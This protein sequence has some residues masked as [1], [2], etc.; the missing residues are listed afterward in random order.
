MSR[1]RRS[2]MDFESKPAASKSA[3]FNY[4]SLTK[5]SLSG[6]RTFGA[7]GASSSRPSKT[8]LK[9]KVT[10][11]E[12]NGLKTKD[13]NQMKEVEKKRPQVTTKLI[14]ETQVPEMNSSS[15]SLGKLHKT[16]PKSES[17]KTKEKDG[18][19]PKTVSSK[20]KEKVSRLFKT[21]RNSVSTPKEMVKGVISSA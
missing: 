14:D 5:S 4:R 3:S 20:M 16:V 11:G 10:T 9:P 15:S 1:Q 6:E 7:R 19:V 21:T 12:E 13:N 18:K 2:S 17:R 8:S